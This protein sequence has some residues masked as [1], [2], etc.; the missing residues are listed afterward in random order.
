MRY[1]RIPRHDNSRR[2]AR[3][4][5]ALGDRRAAPATPPRP[6]W[7]GRVRTIPDRNCFAAVVFMARTSTPW[8]L[9]PAPELGC[10]SPATCWRRLIEWANAGVFDQ[11]H[12]EVLDRLGEQDRLDSSRVSVDSA[13]LRAKRG[14]DHVGANPVDRGK[15]G[16]KI[17]LACEGGG[18]PLTAVIT[19]ANISDVTMLPAVL[20][21]V[22]AVRT[23]SG[24]RRCR[25]GKLDADRGYDSAANRAWLRRRG[26][27]AR[28]ARRG[29][30]SSARL[31]RYRPAGGAGAVLV[32]CYRRLAV[33]WDRGSERFF[34]FVLLACALTWINRLWVGGFPTDR[35]VHLAD[36][37]GRRVGDGSGVPTVLPNRC[38]DLHPHHGLHRDHEAA[39]GATGRRLAP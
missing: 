31:G 33:R 24:Q 21:D 19:A 35:V 12:L 5:R 15:P 3:P 26:I 32:S 10:G 16:S 39:A 2:Q 11:L 30:E 38:G 29:I 20:D 28:I 18:L 6:W 37:E 17:H 9:L 23:P 1:G 25:P 13:S 34:A 36:R 27:T 22:P 8:R 7:G 14:G 4:C